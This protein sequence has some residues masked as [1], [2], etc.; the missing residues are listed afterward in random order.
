MVNSA[1]SEYVREK[2][3]SSDSSNERIAKFV[4]TLQK[5]HGLFFIID[6]KSDMNT[7]SST[8]NYTVDKKC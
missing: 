1:Y 6:T 4:G 3:Q 5:L 8:L 7:N 2:Y